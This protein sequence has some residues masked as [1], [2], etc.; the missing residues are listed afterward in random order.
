MNT[1]DLP[2]RGWRLAVALMAA[3]IFAAAAFPPLCFV[4]CLSLGLL[5][6]YRCAEDAPNWRRAALYGF[7]FGL[8]FN[9]AGLY[10]LTAAPLTRWH[11]FWWA[12]PLAAPGPALILAP[13]A[14][15]PAALCRLVPSGWQ[16]VFLFAGSW[17]LADMGRVFLF[18]GFPW[19]PPG[20]VLEL[21]G[22]VGDW[23]IQPAAWIGVDGMTLAVILGSLIVWQG[24]K[25]FVTVA[26]AVLLWLTVGIVRIHNVHPLPIQNPVVVLAQGNVSEGDIL[27]QKDAVN[28]FR[29]YLSLT[30]EGIVRARHLASEEGAGR[31][32][33]YVWPESAFPGLLN[34]DPLARQVMAQ[35]AEG[36]SG[37]I[38]GSDRSDAQGRYYNSA[39]ALAP[40]GSILDAY[41]KATLVP[42]GE[43]A[44]RFVPVKLVPG[45]LAAGSGPKTWRYPGF[46]GVDPM[47]CYEVIFSG[48]V[49]GP[50]RPSWMLNITNDAW[51]GDTAGPRQHLAT[52]RMRAVE[53]GLPIAQAANTGITAIFDVTGHELGRIGWGQTATLVEAVPS[54][55][56]QTFFA[57]HGRVVPILLSL[58]C[59]GL[60]L[61]GLGGRQGRKH[62]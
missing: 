7:V 21:P 34:E 44:P 37:G 32:I 53:E 6:L 8:A 25:W 29:H 36:A 51:F 62:V 60:S 28:V 2:W 49:V 59:V 46:D 42:F 13:F 38:I 39:F 15:A 30:R 11:D 35:A 31:S 4:P 19:N 57:L 9:T 33:V 24:R 16:R 10:W 58:I 23:L 50:D 56:A 47:V 18:T 20:S 54:P 17:T 12:V 14:A 43:Y 22:R 26:V 48:R 27:G 55:L 45:V 3:G 61:T 52:M 5:F 40:D 1:V 41:D